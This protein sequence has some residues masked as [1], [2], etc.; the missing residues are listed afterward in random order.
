VRSEL[1]DVRPRHALVRLLAA[2]L[3]VNVAIRLRANIL[4]LDG[5]HIG[6][7]VGFA[8]LPRVFGQGGI[9]G[10][11]T[12][13]DHCYFNVGSTFEL[14]EAVTIGR[15]VT[16]GPEV[17]VLTSSHEIGDHGHR[18]AEHDRAPIVIGDGVWV[19][20]R[21]T[22]L[23]G[24]T[25]GAGAVVGASSLVVADV[26]PDTLVAGVPA[27][28]IRQLGPAGAESGPLKGRPAPGS[29]PTTRSVPATPSVPPRDHGAGGRTAAR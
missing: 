6:R 10:H 11:L 22:I 7:G 20:A 4:K 19:G 26:E 16:F 18:C 28:V 13:G 1:A 3:P 17:M 5:H 12:I 24:V 9:A 27:R 2:P 8:D 25:V 29:G 21:A 23:P 15:W 14:G